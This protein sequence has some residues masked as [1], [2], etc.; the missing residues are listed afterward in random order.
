MSLYADLRLARS[1]VS[2]PAAFSSG[3]SH[4]GML[5]AQLQRVL[6][7]SNIY[8]ITFH[9]IC[10]PQLGEKSVHLMVKAAP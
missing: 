10:R 6:A 1:V 4:R 9:V 5:Q 2:L 8:A 7:T 3:A